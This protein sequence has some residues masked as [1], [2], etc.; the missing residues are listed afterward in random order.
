[1]SHW[2]QVTAGDWLSLVKNTRILEN[3]K[4]KQQLNL[5][6]AQNVKYISLIPATGQ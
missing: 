5:T 4:L 2:I 3:T 1:M 6:V